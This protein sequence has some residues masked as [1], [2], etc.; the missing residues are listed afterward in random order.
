MDKKLILKIMVLVLALFFVVKAMRSL[1]SGA[2]TQPVNTILQ[3]DGAKTLDWC[4]VHVVDVKWLAPEVPEHLKKLSLPQLRD[5]YCILEIQNLAPTE[6]KP[7]S[8]NAADL[9][10]YLPL[11][12][13]QGATAKKTTL[14]WDRQNQIFKFENL[15][16]KSPKLTQDLEKK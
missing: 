12:E 2:L 7:D 16:F 11:A 3:I 14:Y 5:N 9:P 13:S 4:A 15:H 8:N 10:A 1:S 6:T